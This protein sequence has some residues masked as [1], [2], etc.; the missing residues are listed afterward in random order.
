MSVK[1]P[2]VFYTKNQAGITLIVNGVPRVVDSSNPHY[3]TIYTELKAGNYS[4]VLAL[5]NLKTAVADAIK[6]AGAE[7]KLQIR[8][9]EIFWNG[10]RGLERVE[11]PLTDRIVSTIRNG[12]TAKAV[13]PLVRLLTNISRNPYK[14]LREEMYQ[15]LMS[16]AMPITHDGCFLAYKKVRNTFKDIYSGKF[17]NSPGK[18]VAMDSSEKRDTNRHNT[19]SHGLHFC[20]RSYLSEYSGI[21]GNKIVVV[22]VNPRHVFAIPTD[23][24]FAKGRASEYF[25]VGECTGNPYTDDAFLAPFIFD[26]N[27]VAGAPGVKFIEPDTEQVGDRTVTSANLAPSLKTIAEG[28]G[29]SAD[30]KAWVRVET[31]KGSLSAETYIACERRE[32][33]KG[34]YTYFSGL[35]GKEVPIDHIR[36]LSIQTKSVRTALARACAKRRNRRY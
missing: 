31:S 35:T 12:L 26:E 24:N 21:D 30:G 7:S 13:Q 18:L 6:E 36:E 9:G 11:G 1:A 33:S 34:N 29:F 14:D 8:D 32:D 2:E 5:A 15:F 23:Y 25:V 10:P 16:G 20:S 17:D 28:Y 27:K 22:K 3:D 19:C 4:R